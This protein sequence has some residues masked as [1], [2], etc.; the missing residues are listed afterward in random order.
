MA[1]ETD[2]PDV[3]LHPAVDWPVKVPLPYDVRGHLAL[4]DLPDVDEDREVVADLVLADVHAAGG[5]DGRR[6]VDVV[7]Q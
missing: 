3:L 4:V 6:R 7:Q 5:G 2:R 1:V